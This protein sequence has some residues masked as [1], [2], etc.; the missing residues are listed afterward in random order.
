ML[1]IGGKTAFDDTVRRLF[2]KIERRIS[3]GV[4]HF[5]RATVDNNGASAELIRCIL[6]CLG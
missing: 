1:L 4:G 3:N 2:E 5:F 6:K